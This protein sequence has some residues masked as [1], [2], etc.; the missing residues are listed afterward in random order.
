MAHILTLT[1]DDP[2]IHI[3]AYGSIQIVGI[4]QP[5]VRCD[6]DSPQLA[7]LVEEDSHVYATVNASCILAVPSQSSLLIEKAMGSVKVSGIK[8]QVQI[9]KVLGNL[10]LLDLTTAVVEKVG[11]NFSVRQATGGLQVEKVAGNLTVDDAASFQG[12][13]VGGSCR[14]K[15]ITGCFY[16]GKAGGKF[17]GESIDEFTGDTNIGGSF[18]AQDIQILGNLNVGGKIKLINA[19]FG[20]DLSLKAGGSIDLSFDQNQQDTNFKMHSGDH[21]IKIVSQGEVMEQRSGSYD[22]QIGQGNIAVTLAAGGSV[23]LRDQPEGEEEILSDLNGQ[24]EFKESAF[25]EMIQDRIDSATKMA[26]AKIKSAEIRLE[27]I[28]ERLEKNRHFDFDLDFGK[29]KEH[30]QTPEFPMPPVIRPVGKKGASD[31]ER[32]MILQMLQ[33]KKI[34]VEDAETLFKALEE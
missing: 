1:R 5:E 27:Q 33:D 22:H 28:R 15:N 30:I 16:V 12:E 4:D 32:L 11:G 9:E 10:V 34:S 13:K 26:E 18:T 7:T 23:T 24:F 31:E 8:N 25:S 20:N 29:A 21:K 2:L 6:I 19:A 3:K 14:V 17:I